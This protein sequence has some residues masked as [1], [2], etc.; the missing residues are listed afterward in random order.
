MT[1]QRTD[2]VFVDFGLPVMEDSSWHAK[3]D[4]AMS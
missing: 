1:A 4:R 3:F 2:T